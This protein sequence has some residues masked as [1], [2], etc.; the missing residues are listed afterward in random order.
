M[1]D[2]I[3]KFEGFRAEAYPDPATGAEPWT[4]GYGTT[5]YLDGRKVKKGDVCTQ[6]EA[7]VY[8]ETYVLWEILPKILDI[9]MSEKQREAVVSLCYNIGTP[10]FLNSK[11]CAAIRAYSSSGSASDLAAIAKEWDFWNASGKPMKGL[12]KR[13][14]AE[15]AL[16]VE[17]A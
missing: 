14:V 12:V 17:G 16:F 3:K 1:Y 13:R 11:L 9:K 8:L 4:I 15:L 5:T 6:L 10:A 2:L 7:A